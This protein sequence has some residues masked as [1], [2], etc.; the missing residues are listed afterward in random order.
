MKSSLKENL[1]ISKTSLMDDPLLQNYYQ[2][3]IKWL[4]N[5]SKMIRNDVSFYRK[6]KTFIIGWWISNLP[7]KNDPFN[8]ENWLVSCSQLGMRWGRSVRVFSQRKNLTLSLLSLSYFLL[9]LLQTH[10]ACQGN[11]VIIYICNRIIKSQ[12]SLLN[13][14][15]INRKRISQFNFK[16]ETYKT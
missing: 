2:L 8:S 5:Y 10:N 15:F 14:I 6:K 11:V 16:F 13:T 9:K 3:I 7:T 12:N 1:Q 4:Q